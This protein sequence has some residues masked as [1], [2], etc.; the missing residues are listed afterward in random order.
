MF[1]FNLIKVNLIPQDYASIFPSLFG[2]T[3]S[4]LK[5]VLMFL[6]EGYFKKLGPNKISKCL[7]CKI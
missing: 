7:S 4:K 1:F 3:E 2:E 5:A 6:Q